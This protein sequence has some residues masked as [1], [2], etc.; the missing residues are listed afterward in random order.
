MLVIPY[1]GVHSAQEQFLKTSKR[2]EDAVPSGVF[3]NRNLHM[4]AIAAR[5]RG[6]NESFE[7]NAWS[8]K[9]HHH[10]IIPCDQ[11]LECLRKLKDE[12]KLPTP[13]LSFKGLQLFLPVP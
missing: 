3:S 8:N 1:P 13:N 10:R 7:S 11:S 5:C 6:S 9:L 4:L 12:T 2:E